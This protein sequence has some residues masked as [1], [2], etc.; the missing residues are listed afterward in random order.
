MNLKKITARARASV[1]GAAKRVAALVAGTTRFGRYRI[2]EYPPTPTAYRVQADDSVPFCLPDELRNNPDRGFRGEIYITLGSRKAYPGNDKSCIEHL[3][4]SMARYQ[5]ENIR[6]YQLYVYLHEYYNRPLA[7][8]ALQQLTDYLALLQKHG[9]RALMR[10]A[11][12]YDPRIRK[13]PTT[14]RIVAHAEQLRLW[15]R[16]NAPLVNRTVYAMQ[17]GMVGLWGEGHS[18]VHRHNRRTVVEAMLAMVPDTMT[19]MMRTPSFLSAVP[20]HHESR[21]SIHDDFLVGIDHPWG[22]IPF[23]HPDYEA[24]IRKC[25]FSLT[26][27]EMPWGADR[28]V[29]H[30]DPILFLRQCVNYGLR[31]LSIEH[32]Y[33][34]DG[35]V[36]HLERWKGVMLNAAQLED[37]NFPYFP[38]ALKDELISVFDYLELHLGYLLAATNLRQHEG[39]IEFDLVNYGMGAP[40]DFVMEARIDGRNSVLV[41]AAT[42]LR[43]FSSIH[44]SFDCTT[45]LAIRF[46]HVRDHTLHIRLANDVPCT[47]GYHILFSRKNCSLSL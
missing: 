38:H 37:N 32:N 26:D 28:T 22:M 17:L 1:A 8:E 3:K 4:E 36:Y 2:H 44:L 6:L 46:R 35:H 7:G 34:E 41:F 10:F 45:E 30:I 27:G 12:E 42:D 33:R 20:D 18:S 13:G 9:I 24:L 40:L 31:T 16:E 19:V 29:P 39:C 43:Q 47:D 15:F 14:R 11:Y 5:K 25:K 23:H 21:S